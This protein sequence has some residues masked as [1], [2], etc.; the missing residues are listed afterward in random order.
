MHL[1]FLPQKYYFKISTK[2]SH[3]LANCDRLAILKCKLVF[4]NI[5]MVIKT[6]HKAVNTYMN[7]I[8]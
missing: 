4:Y 7:L 3:D 2:R 1:L 8:E 5:C 6:N